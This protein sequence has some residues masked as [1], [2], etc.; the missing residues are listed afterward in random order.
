MRKFIYGCVNQ[1]IVNDTFSAHHHRRR[2]IDNINFC[3]DSQHNVN[4]AVTTSQ[5][6]D[7]S[8]QPLKYA[9]AATARRCHVPYK[10]C[11]LLRKYYIC[12]YVLGGK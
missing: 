11:V 5:K 10:L 8:H 3:F 6:K 4:I 12:V 1:P 9:S 7:F 2:C